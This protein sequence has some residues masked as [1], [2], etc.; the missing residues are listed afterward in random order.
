MVPVRSSTDILRT[1]WPTLAGHVRSLVASVIGAE[2]TATLTAA[3]ENASEHCHRSTRTQRRPGGHRA[4]RGR[5][6]NT[7]SRL[8]RSCTQHPHP[9]T[10]GCERHPRRSRDSIREGGK[11]AHKA[12]AP[13]GAAVCLLMVVVRLGTQASGATGGTHTREVSRCADAVLKISNWECRSR[14]ETDRTAPKLTASSALLL[15]AMGHH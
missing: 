6:C 2:E 8:R 3:I 14:A 10:R 9:C 7:T 11:A 15:E 13:R 12:I 4:R 1:I 5:H